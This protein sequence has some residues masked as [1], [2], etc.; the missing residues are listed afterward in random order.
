[1]VECKKCGADLATEA[2]LEMHQEKYC[3]G[4][5]AERAKVATTEKVKKGKAKKG[6]DKAAPVM[7]GR[8]EVPT[9]D[10]YYII[11]S[12]VAEEVGRVIK[13]TD[14][15]GN[16]ENLAVIGPHG[17][18]KT[19][20]AMQIA[21][22]RKSP[23]LAQSAYLARSSDEWFGTET[24][25]LKH[26]M[27][28]N[29]TL[30]VEALETPGATVCIND[31]LL[32]QNKSVQNGLNDLLDPSIRQ[33]WVDAIT[34]TLGRPIRVAPNVLIIATWNQGAKYT[35][36]ITL[37]SNIM[38]RFPNRI[39]MG[40]P[41]VE[42]QI[43][44]LMRKTNVD[45][46]QAQRI[47]NYSSALGNLEEP[48]DVSI[49]SLLQIAKKVALGAHIRDAMQYTIIASEDDKVQGRM[50]AALETIYT[51]DEKEEISTRK[52]AWEAWDEGGMEMITDP[53]TVK[54]KQRKAKNEDEW[55]QAEEGGDFASARPRKQRN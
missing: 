50:L 9:A 48:I 37:A 38:D 17:S 41:P 53:S 28:Y 2:I 26:G 49:R 44:I 12:E 45:Y 27:Q 18:G 4:V 25:D 5:A 23:F 7:V 31:L 15:P 22:L 51:V 36:S 40:Y 10:P 32:M 33:V 46:D 20:L 19:S 16:I 47:C 39:M 13:M 3:P 11:S 24:I 30:F 42:A 54:S 14:E 35:G 8:L 34:R 29:Q 1:M 55:G 21:A 6:E 43:A 52:A